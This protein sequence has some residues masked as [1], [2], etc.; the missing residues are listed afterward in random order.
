MVPKIT[1]YLNMY[2][3]KN[4]LFW[5]KTES[6][7]RAQ[8]IFINKYFDSLLRNTFEEEEQQEETE[9]DYNQM[10]SNS[11]KESVVRVNEW[12]LFKLLE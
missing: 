10:H 12:E 7:I 6:H 3:T 2:T 9:N 5:L 4:A 11:R 1:L 8:F